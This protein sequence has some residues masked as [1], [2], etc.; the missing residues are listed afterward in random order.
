MN[1][2][3]VH[4]VSS[5][6]DIVLDSRLYGGLSLFRGQPTNE[7]LLPSIGRKKIEEEILPTKAF[8]AKEKKAIDALKRRCGLLVERMPTSDWDWLILAQHFGMKTRLLDW[9]TNPLVALWFACESALK[10]KTPDAYVYFLWAID[11]TYVDISV[12][13]PFELEVTKLLMPT[14][15]NPRI[16]AQAGWF[17]AFGHKFRLGEKFVALDQDPDFGPN[18]TEIRIPSQSLDEVIFQLSQLGA[19]NSTIYPDL[20]GLCK[21]LNWEMNL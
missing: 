13:N 19:N 2:E 16:A 3:V 4:S 14:I 6:M 18:L 1:K 11:Q 12:D 17:T 5:Y 20:E 9:S 8:L 10:R 15:N 21:H 7:S